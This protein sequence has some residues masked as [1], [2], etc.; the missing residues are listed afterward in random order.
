MN[1]ATK[2]RIA[3][4]ILLFAVAFF[5]FSYGI[6][7]G[8][9]DL[10]P[11]KSVRQLQKNI[12][13]LA[14]YWQ[15]DIGL[16]PTRTLVDGYGSDRPV[17]ASPNPDAIEPGNVLISG[18]APH[19]ETLNTVILYDREGTELHAWPLDYEVMDPDGPGSLNVIIHGLAVFEDGSIIVN[20]DG[21]Q[22]LARIGACGDVIWQT[23]G[24]FHHSVSRSHDGTIWTLLADE[25]VIET[26]IV[27]LDPNSGEILKKISLL[28][29]IM[30]SNQMQAI[31]ALRT[32]EDEDEVKYMADPFHINQVESLDP[33]MAES[34]PM[35]EA[36]DLLISLR[37]LNLVAVLDPETA[38]V[39][40][41]RIGPWHRQHDP[42]FLHN[43]TILVYDNN[44]SFHKSK[45]MTVD[46]ETDEVEVLFEG[47]EKTPF[48]S[49]RR[50]KVDLLPNN[51][52]LIAESEKGR[53][54]EVTSEGKLV[55]EYN[56]IYDE[57]SNGVVTNAIHIPPDFFEKGALTCAADTRQAER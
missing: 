11:S 55:W 46:P 16:R 4:G 14:F 44:M 26:Y 49:W 12:V 25:D 20:F 10:P 42:Q 32:D 19:R 8:L 6:A 7:A 45:I 3:I 48:Y 39:K 37:S 18:L 2:D 17:A 21:G 28:D 5:A 51:N 53:A 56:N 33:Q 57:E 40:W 1:E 24:E 9:W 41:W 52:L 31:I 35:F 23:E 38:K 29:D 43:G 54:F 47:D 36:G 22:F 34:F 50:G 30:E 15:N 13:D 27:Q